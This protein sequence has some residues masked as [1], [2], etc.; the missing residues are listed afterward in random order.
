MDKNTKTKIE[1]TLL[2]LG[3]LALVLMA[4]R[5]DAEAAEVIHIS[6]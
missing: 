3:L 6:Y 4:G 2:V 5:I 1:I